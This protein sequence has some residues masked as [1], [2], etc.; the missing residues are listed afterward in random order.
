MIDIKNDTL[1]FTPG[2]CDHSTTA[3]SPKPYARL[4]P[5][6]GIELEEPTT[7]R[8]PTTVKILKHIPSTV[9]TPSTFAKCRSDAGMA[10]VVRA[11]PT[12]RAGRTIAGKERSEVIT[13]PIDIAVVGA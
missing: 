8:S 12:G 1:S 9:K 4:Q 2:F 11:E 7:P 10:R 13:K 5:S 6:F 3:Y